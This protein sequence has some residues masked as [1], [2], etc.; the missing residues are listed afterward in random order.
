MR[1]ISIGF[2]AG[3]VHQRFSVKEK[4]LFIQHIALCTDA[5][6][7]L[8]VDLFGWEELTFHARIYGLRSP[9]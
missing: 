1:I 5:K 3:C 9:H 6:L 2:S 7:A 4:M 8:G